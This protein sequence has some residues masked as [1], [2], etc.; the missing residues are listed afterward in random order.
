MGSPPTEARTR[1]VPSQDNVL[2]VLRACE[3]QTARYDWRNLFAA[4]A[5]QLDISPDDATEPIE[6]AVLRGLTLV[7]PYVQTLP[8]DREIIVRARSGVCILVVWAHHVLG[9]N[10]L[11][12]KPKELLSY[13]N[14]I[15]EIP[16]GNIPATVVIEFSLSSTL[17]ESPVTLIEVSSKD[18]LFSI[19]P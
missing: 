12:R 5:A 6:S 16:F 3:E 13:N 14:E 15:D 8:E 19:V 7:F 11:V 10:V 2:G 9:L 17:Q 4:V 18:T 1:A